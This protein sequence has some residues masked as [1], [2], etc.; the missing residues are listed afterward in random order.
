MLCN[1]VLGIIGSCLG[2]ILLLTG[3]LSDF[4]LVNFG[5]NPFHMGLW[6]VCFRDHCM[7]VSSGAEYID[8]TRGLLIIS[9]ALL[10][11]GLLSSGIAFA[12]FSLGRVT[13]PL[14]ASI[15][16]FISA[17]F[18]LIGMSVFTG[19]TASSVNQSSVNYQWSF[20]LSWAAVPILGFAAI[21]HILAHKSS[22]TA[23]YEAI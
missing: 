19:E 23:G 9:T 12:N 10:I 6:Q 7:K 18:L 14:A 4:W 16:E 8:A 2:F 21:C 5:E 15:L 20:Y 22:P 1:N 13:G 3:L 11:L 17:V